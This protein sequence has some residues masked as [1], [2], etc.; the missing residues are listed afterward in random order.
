[1]KML[2]WLPWL[3]VVAGCQSVPPVSPPTLKTVSV[4]GATLTYQEQGTGTPVIFLHGAFSDHRIW[5]EQRAA[6][7]AKY[8]FIS[9]SMRYF[10]TAPWPDDGV[11]F[12]QAN[13]VADLAAFVRELKLGPVY[14]V[15]RSYGAAVAAVT[16]VQHPDLV[17]GLLLNEPPLVTA[18]TAPSDRT[19]VNEELK[20]LAPVVEAVKA[21]NNHAATQ[22]FFDFVNDL[23][24][25]FDA[26]PAARRA[27]HLDNARTVPLMFRLGVPVSCDQL[28]QLKMPVVVVKGALTRPWFRLTAEATSRC[29]PGSQLITIQGARHGAPA[30]Q[31]AAFNAALLAFLA[32]Q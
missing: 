9:L 29:V 25:G 28:G 30:E 12:S 18:L 2:K 22:L 5:E 6:V 11:Q 27:A 19:V 14:L 15:G 20:G 7:A 1:M 31:P 24:G 17:Q 4:N 23:P 13:H 21:G 3:L 26:L 8:R 10:G 32:R 16:A